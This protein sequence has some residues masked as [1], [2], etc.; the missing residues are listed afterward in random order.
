MAL[1]LQRSAH[2]DNACAFYRPD[3]A[4]DRVQR[5]DSKPLPDF[6][7]LYLDR[8]VVNFLIG[9]N[10]PYLNLGQVNDFHEPVH[11]FQ[12]LP[13]ISPDTLIIACRGISPLAEAEAAHGQVGERS[14]PEPPRRISRDLGN[15]V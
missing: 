5:P 7:C 2:D 14:L 13:D 6:K 10:G 1:N 3:D 15:S 12:C 9:E 8:V 11:D 4:W